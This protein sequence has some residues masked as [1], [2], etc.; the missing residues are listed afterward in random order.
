VSLTTDEAARLATLKS[1][2]DKI[3]LGQSVTGVTYNGFQ[4]T[5]GPADKKAVAAE[6]EKLERKAVGKCARARGAMR[7]NL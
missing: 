7:F 1:V 5:F 4:T 6:I 3:I 2:Y